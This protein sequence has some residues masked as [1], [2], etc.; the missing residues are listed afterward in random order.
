MHTL[1]IAR[2]MDFA[3]TAFRPCRFVAWT[4]EAL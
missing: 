4:A 2:Q 1:L 3:P